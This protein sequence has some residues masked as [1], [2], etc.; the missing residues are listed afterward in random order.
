MVSPGENRNVSLPTFTQ[1]K[2]EPPLT[3]VFAYLLLLNVDHG[4]M[5]SDKDVLRVHV[6]HQAAGGQDLQDTL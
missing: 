3:L 2:V 5:N 1:D 4:I 6:V